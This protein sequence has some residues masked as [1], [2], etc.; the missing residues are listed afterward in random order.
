MPNLIVHLSRALFYDVRDRAF[1]ANI[2]TDDARA[3]NLRFAHGFENG[4]ENRTNDREPGS[5]VVDAGTDTGGL[6]AFILA[7]DQ[8]IAG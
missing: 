4:Q 3:E 1:N 7:D 5:D 8:K 2:Q 6:A